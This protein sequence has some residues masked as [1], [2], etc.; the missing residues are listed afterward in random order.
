MTKFLALLLALLMAL[1]V[2]KPLPVPGMR[3][4]RDVWKIAVCG[5]AVFMAAVLVRP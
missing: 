5:L 2:W 1:H 4:R 3:R